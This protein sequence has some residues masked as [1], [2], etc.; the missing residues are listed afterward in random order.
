MTHIESWFDR[1]HQRSIKIQ[2]LKIA[3][4]STSH[5]LTTAKIDID[6]HFLGEPQIIM[7]G[8]TTMHLRYRDRYRVQSQLLTELRAVIEL[9]DAK[10]KAA[11]TQ[12]AELIDELLHPSYGN[13]D[14]DKEKYQNNWK[15][16]I[17]RDSI[18]METSVYRIHLRSDKVHVDE[19]YRLFINGKGPIRA[20][21]RLTLKKSAGSLKIWRG[22]R[23]PHDE[24]QARL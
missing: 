3:D 4:R 17:I 10:R 2:S 6:V 8:P 19:H 14:H 15:E 5:T 22:L 23:A 13:S 24:I 1:F 21:S 11:E 20:I 7:K 9:L 16:N 18:R 12:Q